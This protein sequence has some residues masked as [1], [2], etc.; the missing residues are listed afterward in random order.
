MPLAK[1]L[2]ILF[3]FLLPFLTLP[4]STHAANLFDDMRTTYCNR[5]TGNQLNLETWYGGKCKPGNAGEAIGFSNIILLDVM[6]KLA[7]NS[8][9]SGM[10]LNIMDCFKKATANFDWSKCILGSSREYSQSLAENPPDGALGSIAYNISKLYQNPPASS[11]EYLAYVQ[12]NLSNKH[13]VQPAYAQS[14]GYGY[15]AFSAVL[16]LWKGFRN[17]AYLFFIIAFIVYGFLIMFRMKVGSQTAIGIET[18]IPKLIG[19]LLMIT[20]SYA[21]AGFLVD[22]FFVIVNLVFSVMLTS[23]I[24]TSGSMDWAKFFAGYS[25]GP[26]GP[27]LSIFWFSIW[28]PGWLIGAI[29]PLPNLIVQGLSIVL[30]LMTGIT[31]IIGL[32]VLIAM[33]YSFLKIGWMLLKSYVNLVLQIIFAP[34]IL[35]QEILPGSDAFMNWIKSIIAE[36]SVF[37]SV[38]LM[39][40]L[41]FFFMS[42]PGNGFL[43]PYKTNANSSGNLTI[44][45]PLF[46]DAL[47]GAVGGDQNSRLALVGLGIFL[48]TPKIADMVYKALKVSQFDFSS[49]IGD[50]VN[51]GYEKTSKA[52]RN[53]RFG[54]YLEGPLGTARTRGWGRQTL[55]G[56][57]QLTPKKPVNAADKDA[58]NWM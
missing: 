20:F 6:D 50:A 36:L 41:S 11:F 25:W 32:I 9:D 26:I 12:N 3:L 45:P 42:Q 49:A 53:T 37:A 27:F 46:P 2:T 38:M 1:F 47:N 29:I 13:I 30:G 24:I 21:I 52:S 22:L 28:A 15:Q 31:I 33:L 34:L 14:T 8:N 17:F 19:A 23:G 55:Q 51:F 58:E 7:G 5:R 10:F 40:T 39:F 57:N 43:S 54:R 4:K 56:V 44:L 16:D 35:L 18:A 48:M